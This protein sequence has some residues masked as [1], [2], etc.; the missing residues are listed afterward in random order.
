[1]QLLGPAEMPHCALLHCVAQRSVRHD[2][3][4]WRRGCLAP[5]LLRLPLVELVGWRAGM[6][7]IFEPP[8]RVVPYVFADAVQGL[9]VADDVFPVVALPEWDAGGTP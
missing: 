2:K 4:L 6:Q 5:T 8:G 3:I 9:V 7:L 1:M